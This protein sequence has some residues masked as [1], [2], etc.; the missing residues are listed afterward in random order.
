MHHRSGDF[1]L[2]NLE[3]KSIE[4]LTDYKAKYEELMKTSP[5]R[6]QLDSLE[7]S[8]E[9]PLGS[10]WSSD[11]ASLAF[12][13]CKWDGTGELRIM[14]TN[15][16]I[17]DTFPVFENLKWPYIHD[18]SKD[19]KKILLTAFNKEGGESLLIFDLSDQMLKTL[20]KFDK[21]KSVMGQLSPDG[22]FVVYDH[23]I[24]ENKGKKDIFVLSLKD[25]KETLLIENSGEDFI[26]DWPPEDNRILFASD[27]S[28]SLDAWSIQ[29][30]NGKPFSQP[31]LVKKE[32]GDILP[33]GISQD[34]TFYYATRQEQRDIYLT[35]LSEDGKKLVKPPQR[36]AKKFVGT[37]TQPFWSP[38]G[39][40]LAYVSGRGLKGN[41]P[42]IVTQSMET[43]DEKEYQ[44]NF[45]EVNSVTW[46]LNGVT[47]LLTGVDAE[48]RKGIFEF[49]LKNM[50]I[51]PLYLFPENRVYG[52]WAAWLPEKEKIIFT[53]RVSGVDLESKIKI[54]D[55]ATKQVR[56][57]DNES[58]WHL[59][60][61]LDP[62]KQYLTFRSWGETSDNV[63]LLPVEGGERRSIAEFDKEYTASITWAPDGEKI[64][65]ALRGNS[66]NV[67]LILKDIK[68]GELIDL[69]LKMD[70]MRELQLHPD[71]I[72][73][74]FQATE[75][76]NEIWAMDNY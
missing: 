34:G 54:L 57:I 75:L 25:G 65:I 30:K 11:G 28:G 17:T 71:G 6:A 20:K 37:N 12:A 27:R 48:N 2:F 21:Y 29:V 23:A 55:V 60:E 56:E 50:N 36:V 8:A 64:Y 70:Y 46:G 42:Y 13:W 73:L 52:S 49:D 40:Q 16:E 76:N 69:G 7:K 67:R 32:I 72:K 66:K 61:T 45:R 31:V 24:E 63:I 43:E 51:E 3:S 74:V 59:C 26:L 10:A 4:Y 62:K 18:W 68:S 19:D 47:M 53:H 5:G 33:L 14:T 38:D 22:H 39:T 41:D 44:T 35:V 9:M 15:G 58:T 1:C